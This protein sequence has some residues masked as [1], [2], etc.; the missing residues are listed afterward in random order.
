MGAKMID[1]KKIKAKAKEGGPTAWKQAKRVALQRTPC[2]S[3]GPYAHS[4]ATAVSSRGST[5]APGSVYRY[6]LAGAS[7]SAL[8]VARNA[9]NQSMCPRALSI[10]Y[11]SASGVEDSCSYH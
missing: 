1:D 9:Q 8:V 11:S 2:T 6:L 10:R 7:E 5:T 3:R 4:P